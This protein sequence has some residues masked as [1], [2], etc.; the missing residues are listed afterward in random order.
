[1]K[2]KI[3]KILTIMFLVISLA[4]CT[5]ILTTKNN[6]A[7][8][9]PT[10]GQSLTE[11]IV[12]KPTNKENIKLYEKYEKDLSKLPECKD[13]KITG[14]YEGLWN[15]F[16]VRPLSYA[17]VKLTSLFGSAILS[18]IIITIMIRLILFP[19]T[20]KTAMQSENLKKA[21]PEIKRLEK[22]YEGKTDRE[23]TAKKGQE[24]MLIYKKYNINPASGCIFAI[25]QMPLLFAFIEAINRVP[26]IFEEKVLGLNMGM[27]PWLGITKGNYLY[28]IIPLVIA[29]STYFSFKFNATATSGDNEKQSKMMAILMTVFITFMSFTLSTAIGI[30][31]VVSSGFTVAQNL[32]T[33]RSR[34]HGK[35]NS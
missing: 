27:T 3:F 19:I 14:K 28:I 4:G 34:R 9:N 20:K 24:M 25:I 5:K 7:V 12:C 17:I 31:W 33:D 1:M 10:T 13:L 30:Y 18:I 26:A 21:Q 32:I 6:K 29:A 23:S 16:F 15:T 8:K 35:N 22:K 2:K 11:N